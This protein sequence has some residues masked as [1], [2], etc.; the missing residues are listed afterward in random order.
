MSLANLPPELHT[1]ILFRVVLVNSYHYP[2]PE[3]IRTNI[4]SIVLASRPM[5]ES[6]RAARHVILHRV[7][8][9]RLAATESYRRGLRRIMVLAKLKA[10]VW[11]AAYPEATSERRSESMAKKLDDALLAESVTHYFWRIH[12]RRA[13]YWRVYLL[14]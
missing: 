14:W 9:R 1:E 5:L 4:T 3:I 2:I 11:L 6:W 13:D 12:D 10:C 7:A 8:R